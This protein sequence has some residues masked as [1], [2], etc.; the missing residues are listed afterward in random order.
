MKISKPSPLYA[1]LIAAT[2]LGCATHE[3][4]ISAQTSARAAPTPGVRAQVATA[5]TR[6]LALQPTADFTL[7]PDVLQLNAGA[8]LRWEPTLPEDAPPMTLIA[9]VDVLGGGCQL[10]TCFMSTGG[11]HGELAIGVKETGQGMWGIALRVDRDVR[12]GPASATYVGVGVKWTP[13][14]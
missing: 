4:T 5:A 11:G 3:W 1:L 13:A 6:P 7:G 9:G 2:S 10:R 12:F 8:Q 14:R